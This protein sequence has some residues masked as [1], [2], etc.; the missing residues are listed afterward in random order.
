MQHGLPIRRGFWDTSSSSGASSGTTLRRRLL[1]D[2]DLDEPVVLLVGGGDGMGGIV[3]IASGLE[4]A[5]Q[6]EKAHLVAVC[7][8][9]A[10]ARDQLQSSAGSGMSVMGFVDNMDEWMMASDVLVT[11]AGPGT[12][13][14]ASIC[15]LS[16]IH[17]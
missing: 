16:L 9:N 15:G 12:I 14:E 1:P 5:L 17:I 11:K 7:G 13:A 3:E 8:N 10:A 2:V 6:G 4:Q